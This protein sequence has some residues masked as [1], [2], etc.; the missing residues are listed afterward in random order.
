MVKSL[1]IK[2]VDAIAPAC[3]KGFSPRFWACIDIGYR[4]R[5]S[6]VG[7]G[8]GVKLTQKPITFLQNPPFPIL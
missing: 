8:L 7:A 2:E 3:S 6:N 5:T 1:W 4:G